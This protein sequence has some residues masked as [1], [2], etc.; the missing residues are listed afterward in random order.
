MNE[1]RLSFAI[2]FL[3]A[4]AYSQGQSP[5]VTSA[6]PNQVD[7]GGAA[8]TLTVN[9]SGFASNAVARWSGTAL[10]TRV[11]SDS[12][13]PATVPANLL[14]ICGK[15]PIT[16]T[17]PGAAG[18]TG[19]VTVTIKPVLSALTPNS[20]PAGSGGF[21]VTASG[22]GFSSNVLLVLNAS[23]VQTAL[24]TNYV[25]TTT[26]TA[27]IPTSALTGVFPVSLLVTDPPPAAPRRTLPVTLT[28]ADITAIN[29]DRIS[30]GGPDGDCKW[31]GVNFVPG[32][33]VLWTNGTVST[34][35]ATQYQSTSLLLALVTADLYHNPAQIGIS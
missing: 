26:L 25:S 22:V 18:S 14:A 13:L 4:V 30:A 19:N 33:Q 3:S 16:V 2:L 17:N 10:D 5:A 28:Y 12:L 20:V 1:M 24:T 29:P 34:P 11:A 35:L 23:G 9:G 7:A 27:S 31:R 32:A 8:F 15:S 21:N 6:Q